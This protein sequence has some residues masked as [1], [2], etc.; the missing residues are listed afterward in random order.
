MTAA[1][2][3]WVFDE[4]QNSPAQ[5]IETLHNVRLVDVTADDDGNELLHVEGEC[6]ERA[7]LQGV[8]KGASDWRKNEIG[9]IG[10]V[11][12]AGLAG[13]RPRACHFHSYPDPTLRRAPELDAD[14]PSIEGRRPNVIGWRCDAR[15]GF[16]APVGLT[17]GEYGR[18]IEDR[19]VSVTLRVPAEFVQE[20]QRYG[21][22]P[23]EMLQ[24]FACDAAGIMNYVVN[25]RRAGQ[26]GAR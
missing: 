18:F 5:V 14:E 25:H 7:T 17:P 19:S 21:M 20:C 13:M 11:R 23:A 6:G 16:R 15:P 4:L 12:R 3:R 1:R 10:V 22:T 26:A 9:K 24:G 8:G 2:E